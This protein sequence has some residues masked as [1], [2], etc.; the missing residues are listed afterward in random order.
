MK[1]LRIEFWYQ[2]FYWGSF[3]YQLG[4]RMERKGFDKLD[5]LVRDDPSAL[6]YQKK[7]GIVR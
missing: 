5:E 3:L 1:K 7:R 6:A 2:I 4:D